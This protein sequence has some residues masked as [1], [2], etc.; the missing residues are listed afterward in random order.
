MSPGILVVG[1]IMGTTQKLITVFSAGAATLH[2]WVTF[3]TALM[4]AGSSAQTRER[5]Q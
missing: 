3:P 4:V 1:L 5:A 2:A